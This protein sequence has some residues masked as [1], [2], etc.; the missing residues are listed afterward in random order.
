MISPTKSHGPRVNLTW[1]RPAEPNGV[2]GSYNMFYSHSGGTKEESLGDVLSYLADVLGGV[3]YQ[4]HVQAVTIKPGPNATH[5]AV[6][7]EYS[8]FSFNL[9]CK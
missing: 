5:T 8:K 3:S 6:I 1:S 2:I 9:N 7:A 4:F